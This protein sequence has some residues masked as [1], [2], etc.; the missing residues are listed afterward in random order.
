MHG[1]KAIMAQ[2]QE[3]VTV[4]GGTGFLGR[5]VVRELAKAG[6]TVRVIARN[7]DQG[8]HL[9]TAGHV[10]QVVLQKGDITRPETLAGKFAGSCAVINLVGALYERGRQNFAA[11]HAQGAERLAKEA[12]KVGAERFVHVSA[13]GVNKSQNAKY[14]RTKANGEKAVMAAFPNATILRPSIIFG[15]EDNFYNQFAQMA[16]VAPALPLIGGG[17]T[18]FQPV[19]VADVAR[20]VVATLRNSK[21]RGEVYELGGPRVY[22]FR[23]ILEYVLSQTQRKRYLANLPF[24]A[25]MLVGAVGEWMPTPLLTRDQVQMLKYD[26][27]V[28]RDAKTLADLGITPTPVEMVVPAYLARYRKRQHGENAAEKAKQ[29]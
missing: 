27:L 15:A 25:A 7:P 3:V 1:L 4:V 16:S 14:A 9:K 22:S 6:Y 23:E 5:Y 19:F 26:N 28:D 20:A 13:I 2:K 29:G 21:T 17:K 24:G 8:L 18:R 12:A 10:G 11:L